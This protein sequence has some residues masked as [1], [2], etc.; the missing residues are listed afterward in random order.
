MSQQN[1]WLPFSSETVF[2]GVQIATSAELAA[3]TTLGTTGARL[4]VPCDLYNAG[5]GASTLAS[6]TDVSIP[7]PSDGQV[8]TYDLATGKWKAVSVSASAMFYLNEYKLETSTVIYRYDIHTTPCK[9]YVLQVN[10]DGGN[11][12]SWEVT[13]DGDLNYAGDTSAYWTN[14]LTH[15]SG[16]TTEGQAVFMSDP[17]VFPY[18]RLRIVSLSL[19]TATQANVMFTAIQ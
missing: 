4:V 15:K 19:G 5:S 11:L 13:L 14:I 17:M 1:G 3:K 18:L 16:V 6:L 8:L 10:G 2:G 7:S 9:Y 12:A